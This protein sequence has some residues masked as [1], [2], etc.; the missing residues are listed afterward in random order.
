MFCFRSSFSLP[1]RS[2]YKHNEDALCV[3]TSGGS[4]MELVSL[5]AN[6][7]VQFEIEGDPEVPT[8]LREKLSLEKQVDRIVVERL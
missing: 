2:P 3:S 4:L 8:R 5:D 1:L 6:L 7:Y